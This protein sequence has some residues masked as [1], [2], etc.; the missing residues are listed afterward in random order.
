MTFWDVWRGTVGRE[1]QCNFSIITDLFLYLMAN[2]Y[3]CLSYII[4]REN[5]RL[6]HLEN[7]KSVHFVSIVHSLTQG[8]AFSAIEVYT[9]GPFL[10]LLLLLRERL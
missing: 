4:T 8:N 7:I 10:L 1:M 9:F 6:F 2:L 5:S 3:S